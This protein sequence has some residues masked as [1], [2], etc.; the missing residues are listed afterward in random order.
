M[1]RT[2]W[3]ALIGIVLLAACSS[4]E[5]SGDGW[6]A[7]GF[8]EAEEIAIAPEIAG[9]VT[10]LPVDEGDEVHAGDLLLRLDDDLLTAQA[11]LARGKL[12]E[13][14]AMLA[15]AKRGARP[16]T[17]DKFAAQL[18]LAEAARDGAQQAW[19][20]AQAV[21]DNPQ[22]L[23]VQ[24]V[25]AR[26]EVTATQKQFEAALIQR[27]IAEKAWKDYG[28]TADKLADV[29]PQYRPHLPTDYYLIPYQWQQA[30]V[31]TD[32]ALAQYNG[33]R[34]ALDNLLAQRSDP[35]EAQAQVD[36]AY[37]RYQSAEATVTQARAALE[38]IQAG[39]TQDQIDTAQA[40]VDVAQAGLEAAQV[41]LQKAT[42]V[43]PTGGLIVAK[44][45]HRGEVASPNITALK[46]ADLDHVTLTIY[47][48]GKR[49]GEVTL[50]Q[51]VDVKVDAFSDR[52]FPGSIMTIAD[53][54]EYT[55]RSVRTADERADLVYAVKIKIDNPDHALKPGLQAEAQMGK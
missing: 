50:G 18:A 13:A 24:I 28:E 48:P 47:V 39:A 17:I 46:L 25:A 19:V 4:T 5:S 15:Q 35:Q 55:P 32:A 12:E 36:A 6:I 37:A 14:Q 26:A 54:A 33:A 43:A 27:D 9:R 52:T 10:E 16:V 8:I 53:Q 45:L 7:S 3:M 49:L 20:D 34:E 29:P 31:A 44:S 2:L 11:D 42:V 41:Q 30:I 38:G 22:S 40:Q 23:N 21:R 1:N 51:T